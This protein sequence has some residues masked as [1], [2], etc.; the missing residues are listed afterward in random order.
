MDVRRLIEGERQL[1][2]DAEQAMEANDRMGRENG[3][4]RLFESARRYGPDVKPIEGTDDPLAI[5]VAL[6][7]F[8][9]VDPRILLET[10]PPEEIDPNDEQS[11]LLKRRRGLLP[12]MIHLLNEITQS[13]E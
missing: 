7:R 13:T 2:H 8:T 4:R 11:R 9:V 6:L 1:V 10:M 3:L 5:T 12:H